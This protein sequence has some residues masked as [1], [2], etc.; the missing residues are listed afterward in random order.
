LLADEKG[1]RSADGVHPTEKGTGL[2]AGWVG[3]AVKGVLGGA[4]K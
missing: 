1:W 2:I 3:E 4:T